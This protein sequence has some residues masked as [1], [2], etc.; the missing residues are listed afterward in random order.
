M[1]ELSNHQAESEKA[2]F[3]FKSGIAYLKGVDVEKNIEKAT[4]FLKLAAESG[5]INAMSALGQ[6]LI[7][8]SHYGNAY[9]WLSKAADLGSIEA[10]YWAAFA[11]KHLP[12]TDPNRTEYVHYLTKAANYEQRE[13]Q[14]ELGNY[15]SKENLN[16]PRNS[17]IAFKWFEKAG[18]QGSLEGL[19]KAAQL[20][21]FDQDV[22]KPLE[23][24]FDFLSKCAEKDNPEAQALLGNLY[25]LGVGTK[26]NIDLGFR[27]LEIA[28]DQ[29]EAY[30]LYKLGERY[31]SGDETEKNVSLGLS[32]L[33]RSAKQGNCFSQELLGDIYLDQIEG[34]T[35]DSL[36]AKFW[37]EKAVKQGSHSACYKLSNLLFEGDEF[38]NVDTIKALELLRSLAD[39]NHKEAQFFLG[40][41]LIYGTQVPQDTAEGLKWI[42]ELANSGDGAALNFLGRLFEEGRIFKKDLKEAINYYTRALEKGYQ[43]SKDS[44]DRANTELS[45]ASSDT[46]IKRGSGKK[47]SNKFLIAVSICIAIA[48]FA[49]IF[50]F[51]F[52]GSIKNEYLLVGL[53]IF[54]GFIVGAFNSTANNN[55][56]NEEN[57]SIRNRPS[58][59]DGFDFNQGRFDNQNSMIDQYDA[60]YTELNRKKDIPE[61]IYVNPLSGD[62]YIRNG[63][64]MSSSTGETYTEIGQGLWTDSHNKTIQREG[65][66]FV[67][68]NTGVRSSFGDPFKD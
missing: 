15:F 28:A 50:F 5:H 52:G 10:P 59:L 11:I 21:L 45:K 44:I 60:G 4:K 13:A 29:N 14:I 18:K 17:L 58:N 39:S 49:C 20:I 32:Y 55:S 56:S 30:A 62:T 48:L 65:N 66:E 2:E 12:S 57:F 67:N 24:A 36:L 53:V 68:L 3:N 23:Q 46:K 40:W 61:G 38:V 9:K 26:K 47:K 35:K 54:S 33:N 51:N 6:L 31:F 64:F 27:W 7:E 63:S 43:P 41:R 42:T 37:Y 25:L 19:L 34:V 22:Q 16:G 1:T 8:D